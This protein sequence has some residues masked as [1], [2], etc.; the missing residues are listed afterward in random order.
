MKTERPN[1][2]E[3]ICFGAGGLGDM[4]VPCIITGFMLIYLTNVALL[5]VAACSVIIGISR[6][7][8]G[9]SDIIIGNIIDNTRSKL[10]K[11]RS[12]LLRMC[13]PLFVF[14]M[15]LFWVPQDMPQMLKYVYVFVLYNIVNTGIVTFTHISFF[16]L[17]SLISDDKDEHVVLGSIVNITRFVS[18][19]M[20][21]VVFVRLLDVF[22]DEPGNQN[23]QI[24]YTRSVFA[25]CTASV[26]FLL[27]A[28]VGTRERVQITLERE[29]KA[30]LKELF[31]ALEILVRDR[32][33]VTL[34]IIDLLI[35]IALQSVVTAVPYFSLYK[36]HDMRYMSQILLTA[37][38]P[39]ILAVTFMPLLTG[40]YGKRKVFIGAILI[41]VAGLIG[42]G[43]VSPSVKPLLLFNLLY[44]F[45]NGLVK[46]VCFTLVADLV[47]VTAKKTGEF[48]PGTGNAGISATEKLG[49][50]LGTVSFGFVLSAVGF[51]AALDVQPAVVDTVITVMFIWVPVLIYAA[52]LIIYLFFFDKGL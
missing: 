12:W 20:G 37:M 27:I 11:A 8:D 32:Y 1:W 7:F 4:L 5:D 30:P 19:L 50:G 43:I 41:S 16:S 45:G 2:I 22:T 25:A 47:A 26:V 13:L 21:S 14:S 39:Q 3:R 17:V 23:T 35:N 38:V 9:I 46:G 49:A 18:V 6:F 44:G 34:V 51:N 24:A 28:V 33:W 29:R 15:L 10:G 52:V 48:R 31:A 36:L 40:R 42:I